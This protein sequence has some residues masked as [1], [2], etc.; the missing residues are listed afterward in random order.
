MTGHV[1]NKT[2]KHHVKVLSLGYLIYVYK[3]SECRTLIPP[4]EI[5]LRSPRP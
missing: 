2:R 3:L 1:S 4:D 5:G